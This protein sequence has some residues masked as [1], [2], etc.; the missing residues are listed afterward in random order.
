MGIS[1]Q[2]T[3]YMKQKNWILTFICILSL[4][5]NTYAQTKVAVIM[6]FCSKQIIQKPNTKNSDLGNACREYYQGSLL[7]ADSL[8]A[9]G[10]SLSIS[11]FDTEKDSNI[12][13]KILKK[14]EIAEADLII[15][16]VTKE[17]QMAMKPYSV[18]KQKYHVSPL[19]TFTKTKVNDPYIISANPDLTYYADYALGYINNQSKNPNIIIIQDNDPTDKVFGSRAK[20][21]QGSF[22]NASFSYLDISKISDL[23]KYLTANKPNHIILCSNEESKVNSCLNV[24]IDTTGLYDISTYGFTQWMDFSSINGKLWEQCKVHI[25]TPQFIDYSDQAVKEFIGRYRA[26]FYTEPSIFAFQ[27][28]DQFMFF[29]K[30]AS[31]NKNDIKKLIEQNSYQGLCNHF[32][33]TYKQDSEGLQ[34][35]NLNILRWQNMK[36]VRVEY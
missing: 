2:S 29:T 34:N 36:L 9:S 15:G 19:F 26:K 20:Q 3:K 18:S 7:A 25:L 27:G 1:P 23:G 12:F 32:K 4:V 21:L 16:P 14:K 22:S 13:I 17:A 33:I 31:Q 11:S 5:T 30:N 8:I 6:P 10:M 24:I 28:Y 35:A